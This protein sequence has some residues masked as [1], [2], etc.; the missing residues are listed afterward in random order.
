MICPPFYNFSGNSCWFASI[1]LVQRCTIF[2]VSTSKIHWMDT[3]LPNF[4]HKLKGRLQLRSL[5]CL[6]RGGFENWQLDVSL[7]TWWPGWPLQRCLFSEWTHEKLV[8]LGYPHSWK[9]PNQRLWICCDSIEVSCS[10]ICKGIIS[11]PQGPQEEGLVWI[12]VSNL[13]Q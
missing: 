2:N 3:D 11:L 13:P 6:T 9:Q 5:W 1:G 12:R 4:G 7:K 8:S 10:M